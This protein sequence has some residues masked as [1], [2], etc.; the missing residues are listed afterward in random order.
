[1]VCR[2]RVRGIVLFGEVIYLCLGVYVGHLG[3][4][5]VML[6]VWLICWVGCFVVCLGWLVIYPLA[7]P[8]FCADLRVTLDVHQNVQM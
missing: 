7:L 6:S 2:C 5:V 8:G 3:Q 1:M 4:W